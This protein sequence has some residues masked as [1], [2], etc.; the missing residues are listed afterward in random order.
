M[1]RGHA[2]TFRRRRA[3]TRLSC[4]ASFPSV[5]C[6]V[7]LVGA[8]VEVCTRGA[9]LA[10]W[11]V[12]RRQAALGGA[13]LWLLRGPAHAEMPTKVVQYP[14][15]A[16]Q[17]ARFPGWFGG[18]TAPDIRWRPLGAEVDQLGEAITF[19]YWL[20]GTWDAQYTVEDAQFPL[21]WFIP[22]AEVPGI[23]MGSALR[24][25]NVGASPLAQWRFVP[26]ADNRVKYDWSTTLPNL[27]QAFWP[28]AEV[29]SVTSSPSTG[30]AISYRSPT[31]TGEKIGRNASLKV[32]AGSSWE[33]ENKTSSI[34]WLRQ[35]DTLVGTGDYKVI[36]IVTRQGDG[37]V[38]GF[39]R[40]A[41]FLQPIDPN[42]IKAEDKAVAVFDYSVKL[43]KRLK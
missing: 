23:T 41:S 16:S 9:V 30:C 32:L 40:I 26:V 24:L 7:A 8:A 13:A 39:V 36:K 11:V 37:S 4:G 14:P 34:E 3:S 1:V 31:Q 6:L 18:G 17:L 33:A 35:T 28:D 43:T 27:L 15:W 25:P 21:G 42:Y 2:W 20:E 12:P 19:P 22:N 38:S 29:L 5:I 10:A